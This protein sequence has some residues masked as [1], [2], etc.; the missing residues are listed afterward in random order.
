MRLRDVECS[1]ARL[2]GHARRLG[3]TRNL[4]SRRFD[5][6]HV[7]AVDRKVYETT[8]HHAH[9][10]S[11][12]GVRKATVPFS[13]ALHAQSSDTATA[14]TIEKNDT[15]ATASTAMQR[16]SQR[17]KKPNRRL[18]LRRPRNRNQNK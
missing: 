16:V 2:V 14:T 6:S 3:A 10:S 8:T 13:I 17:K 1:H 15:R 9:T 18:P 5:G 12:A 4:D 11:N 7:L